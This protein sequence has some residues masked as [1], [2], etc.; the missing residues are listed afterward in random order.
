MIP[1][2]W[3]PL[4][5]IT[6]EVG[7]LLLCIGLLA[8]RIAFVRWIGLAH[9]AL[10]LVLLLTSLPVHLPL[11]LNRKPVPV[12]HFSQAALSRELLVF[13]FS[14]LVVASLLAWG[15]VVYAARQ[16]RRAG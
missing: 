5:S 6:A 7:L 15:L 14:M 11:A 13:E 3:Q 1:Q 10:W 9:V 8:A 16:S 4:L 12:G 2:L